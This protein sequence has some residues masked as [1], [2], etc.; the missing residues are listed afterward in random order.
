MQYV[1]LLGRVLV[2]SLTLTGSTLRPRPASEKGVIASELLA[3]VWPLLD[4]GNIT[5]QIDT[6]FDLGDA[7]A[8]HERMESS[9]HM[10]KI[11][12]RVDSGTAHY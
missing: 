8:A 9:V 11:M 7:M 5:P 3:H 2:N 12:L 1:W 6:V 4:S 10:G